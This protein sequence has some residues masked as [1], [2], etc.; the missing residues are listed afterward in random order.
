MPNNETAVKFP[1]VKVN[2]SSSDGNVFAVLGKVT[3]AMRR[4]KVSEADVDAFLEEA[5]SGDYNHAL[6]TCMKWVEVS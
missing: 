4:A 2:L 6:A 5:T 3:G 1:N